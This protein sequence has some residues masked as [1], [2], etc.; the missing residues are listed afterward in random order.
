[1]SRKFCNIVFDGKPAYTE[2]STGTLSHVRIL[3]FTRFLTTGISFI[4]YIYMYRSWISNEK[5]FA[6]KIG[7]IYGVIYIYLQTYIQNIRKTYDLNCT[8]PRDNP[9]FEKFSQSIGL[10]RA[11]GPE[12]T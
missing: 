6:L 8:L 4:V 5:E 1:M 2:D 12:W 3:N 7:F 10:K 9:Y 11:S